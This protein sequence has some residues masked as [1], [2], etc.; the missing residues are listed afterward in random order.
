MVGPSARMGKAHRR[1]V[2]RGQTM[3]SGLHI[4]SEITVTILNGVVQMAAGCLFLDIRENLREEA[5]A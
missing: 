4:P 1:G 5:L 2:G 3:S